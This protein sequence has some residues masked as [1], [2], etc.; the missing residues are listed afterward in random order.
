MKTLLLVAIF[1]LGA[2]GFVACGDGSNPTSGS[3]T[4]VASVT[5]ATPEDTSVQNGACHYKTNLIGGEPYYED[6]DICVIIYRLD[7]G[8]TGYMVYIPF[9]A[10]IGDYRKQKMLAEVKI[11][12]G[13]SRRDA[14]QFVWTRPEKVEKTE[15]TTPDYWT[16]GCEPILGK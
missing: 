6:D 11:K 2:L 4:V 15:M 8:Q 5:M 10:T 13:F 3:G 9:A 1:G 14:C 12:E 16:K 7:K